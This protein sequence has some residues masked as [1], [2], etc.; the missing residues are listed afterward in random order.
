M[1]IE[2][3]GDPTGPRALFEPELRR[4]CTELAIDLDIAEAAVG[5]DAPP[6]VAVVFPSAGS[7]WTESDTDLPAYSRFA[8]ATWPVLPVITDAPQ[9]KRLPSQISRFNAFQTGL[10]QDVWPQGLV[11]EVLSL[12]WQRRRDRRMFISYKRS[13]SGPVARQLYEA[14]TARGYLTFLD[15]VSIAKGLEFQRELKWWLTDADAMIVLATPGFESSRWCIEE[16]SSAKSGGIGLL[17]V[18][19]PPE[20]F[21]SP[22]RRALPKPPA[23]APGTAP[24]EPIDRVI[25]ADQQQRLALADFE[26]GPDAALCEQQLTEDGLAKVIAHCVRQRAAA[27]RLRLENLIPL[28]EHVLKPQHGLQAAGMPGDYTFFDAGGESHF[29]RLLPFRPDP[30]ALHEVFTCA[31]GEAIV[32]CLYSECDLHDPRARAMRWLASGHR[33]VA[34]ASQR[35]RIWACVGDREI[36]S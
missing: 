30:H 2:I 6:A 10:W 20:V 4:Q 35:T 16:I 15:D 24:P 11:D 27:I 14:L 3:L 32:G 12:G 29:V 1:R 19:W 13:D 36:S 25:D 7:D 34:G 9:A 17:G 5:V 31:S 26:G 8:T 33:E 23:P 21:G 28:A 18:V 22:P